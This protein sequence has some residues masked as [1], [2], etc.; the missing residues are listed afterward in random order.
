VL[1]RGVKTPFPCEPQHWKDLQKVD[2]KPPLEQRY[3]GLKPEL[4]RDVKCIGIDG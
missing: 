4:F 3:P 2:Q 1:I